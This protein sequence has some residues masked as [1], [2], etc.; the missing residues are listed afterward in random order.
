MRLWTRYADEEAT[1]A[2]KLPS[3]VKNIQPELQ[4][5]P[6]EEMLATIERI[7]DARVRARW[8]KAATGGISADDLKPSIARLTEMVERMDRALQDTPWLAGEE[9]SL[10]NI[11]IAPFV[12]RLVRADLFGLVA[13]RP[14]VNDWYA[15]MTSRPAYASAMPPAGSEGSQPAPA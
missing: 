4:R 3:F 15:R 13:A 9:Y 7:P 5:M 2:V 1:E 11:D 6:R 14:R 12:Q 8:R 10:A